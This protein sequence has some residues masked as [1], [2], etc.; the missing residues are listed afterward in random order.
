MKEHGIEDAELDD[1]LE[2][3]ERLRGE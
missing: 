1:L 2:A 3:V